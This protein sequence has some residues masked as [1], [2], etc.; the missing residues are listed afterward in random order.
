[1]ITLDGYAAS[2][3]A[4]AKLKEVGTLPRRVRVRSCNFEQRGRARSSPDKAANPADARIQAF[5]DGGDAQ[6]DA[7]VATG[8]VA[9]PSG[10]RYNIV[11]EDGDAFGDAVFMGSTG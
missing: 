11:K 5:R 6:S 9:T 2:H 4:V 7:Q 1:M 3:R 10:K 8:I